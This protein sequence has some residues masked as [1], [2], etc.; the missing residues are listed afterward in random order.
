[1]TRTR[2]DEALA[3]HK[4]RTM[5]AL[6]LASVSL[7]NNLHDLTLVHAPVHIPRKTMAVV[8]PETEEGAVIVAKRIS[9]AVG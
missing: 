7:R 4:V 9:E 8:I 3:S 2:A 6:A 1:M 5:A